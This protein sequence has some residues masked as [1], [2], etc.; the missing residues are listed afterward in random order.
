MQV[1]EDIIIPYVPRGA[2]EEV[3]ELC[4][5]HRFGV[6][7]AHRRWGKSVCFANELI[8]RALSTKLGDYRAGFVGPTYTMAKSILWDELKRYTATVPNESVTFNESELRVDFSNGSRIRLFGGDDPQRLRGMYFDTIV[9]DEAD[10]M[11]MPVWTEVLRP[12]IS[13]R[14]GDAYFIGT[15]KYVDGP[16]GQLYDMGDGDGW[17]RR[18]YKASETGYLD[19]DELLEAER[20]MSKEEYAREYECVRVASVTGSILGRAV[21]EA[22]REGRITSVPYDPA[23]PVTT[24]WD[25]GIGDSTSIWFCQA[26]RG[27]GEIRLI[28]FYENNGE[29]LAHYAQ[30]LKDKGYNYADHIAP[31]DMGVRELGTG[32]TR[33]EVAWDLG[34][35]FRVL[36][37][38]SQNVRSE[39]DERIEAARRTLPRCWF[40]KEKTKHGVHALRSWRRDESP[41]TGELQHTPLHDWASHA[42]DSFTYLCVGLIPKSSITR[43]KPNRNWMY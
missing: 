14:K 6:V 31:H 39:I 36:P 22:D 3:H 21:D 40:D 1:A 41:R 5:S 19:S 16:L 24:S 13:D 12:A 27:S 35:R 18:T 29:G 2:Q 25:I 30:V 17:F 7:V 28:D 42:A 38:V 4:S 37:R 10:L 8:K 26:A 9:L 23:L 20:I 33:L 43:P 15:Y 32:K 11:K 34:I